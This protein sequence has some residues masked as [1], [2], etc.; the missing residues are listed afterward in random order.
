MAKKNDIPDLFNQ[1][2]CLTQSTIVK[3]VEGKLDEKESR[4]V[5]NHLDTCPLCKDA[6]EGISEI[7][8]DQFNEDIKGLRAEFDATFSGKDKK[9]SLRLITLISAAASVII[10]LGV[11]FFYYRTRQNMES[12]IAESVEPGE[13]LKEKALPVEESSPLNEA[14]RPVQS[15]KE[16]THAGKS[17]TMHIEPLTEADNE[18]VMEF[19]GGEDSVFVKAKLPDYELKAEQAGSEVPVNL[20]DKQ[21]LSDEA[22]FNAV[23]SGKKI[24]KSA[25]NTGLMQEKA[26]Q[27][28]RTALPAQ[29]VLFI[30]DEKPSFKGGDV[31]EFI[32][33]LQDQLNTSDQLLK[34][35]GTDSILV[36]FVV[37]TLGRPVNIKIINQS[38]PEINNEIIRLFR[39]SPDWVPGK[40][41]G[42]RID[43]G[44]TISVRT[45]N[46]TPK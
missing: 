27:E 18:Q 9:R 7:G 36:S 24:S 32:K 26:A 41:N 15:G 13:K 6:V 20:A 16:K 5:L 8:T 22:T 39:S 4:L 21:S 46:E 42:I 29:Q 14:A 25:V 33:Y 2:G 17:V 31:N 37:D 30:K 40:E 23:A 45:H 3:F 34:K 43:V 19:E 35:M 11:L 28:A 1:N 12:H 44:Y 38:D 10:V